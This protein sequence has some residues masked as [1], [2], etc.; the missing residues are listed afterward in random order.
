MPVDEKSLVL[1]TISFNR[2]RF[3]WAEDSHLS[4]DRGF[5]YSLQPAQHFQK[6]LILEKVDVRDFY[7]T[8]FIDPNE[9][10]LSYLGPLAEK[11]RQEK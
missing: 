7:K 4:T 11:K 5:H 3:R 8:A 2:A 9:H 10:G 1:R 6:E